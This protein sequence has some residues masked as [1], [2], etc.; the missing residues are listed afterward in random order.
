MQTLQVLSTLAEQGHRPHRRGLRRPGP[1]HGHY[2]VPGAA[3][4]HR[5]IATERLYFQTTHV[6]GISIGNKVLSTSY[7]P[8]AR[9]A[10][11]TRRPRG[12]SAIPL[13]EPPGPWTV[14]QSARRHE[15]FRKTEA[16]GNEVPRVLDRRDRRRP[17][18]DDPV[19][20]LT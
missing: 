11:S 19:I 1:G 2:P 6:T 4:A 12:R 3:V 9:T 17:L 20:N 16:R 7:P 8:A 15:M 13:F 5:L 18:L 14:V 10:R